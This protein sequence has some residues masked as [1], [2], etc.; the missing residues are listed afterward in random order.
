[1]LK[2]HKNAQMLKMN[3]NAQMLKM[4]RTLSFV[5]RQRKDEHLKCSAVQAKLVN[6]STKRR[7]TEFIAETMPWILDP[8]V[9]HNR[10]FVIIWKKTKLILSVKTLFVRVKYKDKD[11]KSSID[12]GQSQSHSVAAKLHCT[13]IELF[14]IYSQ[15]H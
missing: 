5:R 6:T 14:Q 11:D 4:Q 13:E 10:G 9:H 1:M 7:T 15:C 12:A 2:M 8:C 3:K